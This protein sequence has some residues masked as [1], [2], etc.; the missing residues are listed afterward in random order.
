M[1][2][3]AGAARLKLCNLSAMPDGFSAH[4]RRTLKRLTS[5]CRIQ[6]FLDEE[7][8]YNL[9]RNGETCYSPRMVLREGV[10]HCMEGALLGA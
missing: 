6:Q 7:I 9:E 2:L 1:P 4:E 5:P 10:A 8:T 3:R